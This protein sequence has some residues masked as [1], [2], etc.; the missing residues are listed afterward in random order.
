MKGLGTS[1]SAAKW[2]IIAQKE[3]RECWR[4]RTFHWAA[5]A[6]WS[7][8]VIALALGVTRYQQTAMEQS[9]LRAQEREVWVSQGAKNSHFAM[10]FGRYALRPATPMSVLEPGLS[11]YVGTAIW[12]E[13]HVWNPASFR[14]AEDTGAS[15]RVGELSVA[16]VQQMLAPLLIILCVHATMTR[17]HEQGTY[18]ALMTVGVSPRTLLGGKLL[19]AGIAK[20]A[21]VIPPLVLSGVVVSLFPSPHDPDHW[22][23]LYWW[24]SAHGLYLA[25][26][27]VL[28]SL[29]SACVKS[30]RLALFI[31]LGLWILNTAI[32]PRVA[33][34]VAR[35]WSPEPSAAQFFSAMAQEA[36]A[37]RQE[38]GSGL[39]SDEKEILARYGLRAMDDPT[40]NRDALE[41]LVGAERDNR[42]Q[43]RYWD[44]LWTIYERQTQVYHMISLVAPFLAVRAASMGFAGTDLQHHEAFVRQA[45]QYRRSLEQQVN[46]DMLHHGGRARYKYTIDRA[47]YEQIPDFSYAP[48][49]CEEVLMRHVLSLAILGGWL[50]ILAGGV[51]G[52]S[53]RIRPGAS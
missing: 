37:T 46:E 38:K 15:G 32:A 12:I 13:A 28:S 52:M 4:D 50:V 53:G 11:A 16:V 44:A 20:G 33:A 5:M 6:L 21:L 31:L 34:D 7:C 51:W 19:G 8:T 42:L 3:L 17:E 36:Q 23:R 18:R 30:S 40:I 10:H 27:V 29:V 22:S 47:F 48:V 1:N 9:A 2:P 26:F 14:A 39:A 45:E 43:S 35:R 41:L 25:V 24:L 49:S